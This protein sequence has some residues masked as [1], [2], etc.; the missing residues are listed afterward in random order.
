VSWKAPWCRT[1]QETTMIT[2]VATGSNKASPIACY[3]N[4]NSWN[5]GS[6]EGFYDRN[7]CSAT[8]IKGQFLVVR[9]RSAID[10]NLQNFTQRQSLCNPGLIIDA[11]QIE[12][13]E[14]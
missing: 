13:N 6:I 4:P 2:D 9:H 3:T 11:S 14:P 1:D 12:K 5:W 8:Q 7:T 10:H